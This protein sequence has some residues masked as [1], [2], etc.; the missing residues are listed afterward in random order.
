M[1]KDRALAAARL[2][3]DAQVMAEITCFVCG[4]KFSFLSQRLL[5]DS[6]SV[7]ADH[8]VK[9]SPTRFGGATE[10]NIRAKDAGNVIVF[11]GSA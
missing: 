4:E 9:C 10:R 5:P 11:I 7:V 1:K 8:L 6:E 2:I 3:K